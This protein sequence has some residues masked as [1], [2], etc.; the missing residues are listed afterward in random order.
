MNRES[1]Y[2]YSDRD[3]GSHY[4]RC[5]SCGWIQ[6]C[7]YADDGKWLCKACCN[8]KIASA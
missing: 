5:D 6:V 4:L 2:Q 3:Q 8:K 1:E 7:K